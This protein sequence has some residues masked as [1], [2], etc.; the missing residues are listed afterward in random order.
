[1]PESKLDHTNP[2]DPPA[3]IPRVEKI[4]DLK[5]CASCKHLVGVRGY[6]N[7][8]QDAWRCGKTKYGYNVITG[9]PLY[10]TCIETRT[11]ADHCGLVGSWWEEYTAPE[12][13]GY[14][15]D[16]DEPAK[17]RKT[18]RDFAKDLGM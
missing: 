9:S 18:S 11:V 5:S 3:D 13:G 6:T 15:A 10:K 7:T 1:M 16:Q 12:R 8:Y 2:I 14:L 17:P 4:E